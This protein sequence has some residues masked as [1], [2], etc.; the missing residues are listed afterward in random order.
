M[1]RG[2][3]EFV[4]WHWKCFIQDFVIFF[5]LLIERIRQG[6]ERMNRLDRLMNSSAFFMSFG[7]GERV[8]CLL[9][10][11]TLAIGFGASVARRGLNDSGAPWG[12]GKLSGLCISIYG[13]AGTLDAIVGGVSLI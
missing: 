10:C 13:T 3:A 5:F 8:L 11:N 2:D 4:F 9:L 12:A 1:T 7:A 6:T